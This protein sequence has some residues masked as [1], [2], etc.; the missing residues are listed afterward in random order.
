MNSN[1][2]TAKLLVQIIM[3][4]YTIPLCLLKNKDHRIVF[5]LFLY[6]NNE[7]GIHNSIYTSLI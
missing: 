4:T 3:K 2:E 7:N 5:L 6:K 1:S